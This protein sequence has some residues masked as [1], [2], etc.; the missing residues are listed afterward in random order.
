MKWLYN[1][2]CVFFMII[3]AVSYFDDANY[4]Y[5]IISLIYGILSIVENTSNE[6]ESINNKLK[7]LEKKIN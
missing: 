7:E 1:G 3:F 5:F 4:D 2:L 6:V